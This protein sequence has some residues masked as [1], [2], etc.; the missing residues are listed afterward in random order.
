MTTNKYVRQAPKTAMAVLGISNIGTGNGVEFVVPPG[1]HVYGINAYV[2]T[3]FNGTTNTI[4]ASDGTTTFI[5]AED[6]KTAGVIA[7]DVAQKYFPNG[8]TIGVTLAQTGAATAG[9]VSVVLSYAI[10]GADGSIQE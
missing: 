2:S 10:N 9:V 8:G 7:V 4:S 5:S 6:V 1:S 3:Q